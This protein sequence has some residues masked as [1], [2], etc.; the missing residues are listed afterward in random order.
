[1]PRPQQR[2]LHAARARF[3]VLVA[4]R[5]FG[6]TVFCINELISRA[7]RCRKRDPRFAYVAPFQ[8]QAK[9]VA[10]SYLKQYT[11]AIPGIAVSETELSVDLPPR[12]GGAGR[13]R[14]RLYGAD[15][16]DR[17]RGLYFDG[18]I[19]DEYA[20]MDPRVWSE[21]IRP[22]LADRAGWAIFI[23]TPLGRNAFC[24]LYEAATQGFARE[25]GTRALDPDWTGYL[26]K[27]TETGIIPAA[28]LEAARRIM[29]P[30]QYA[31]EFECSFDA[32][33]PGAYYATLIDQ[34][35][36]A[37]RLKPVPH[38]PALPVHTAWDLGIG[39]PTAIWFAQVVHGEPR[40]IDYYESSGVGLEH[41]VAQLHAGHRAEWVYG[42]HFFPPDL[43][44]REIGTG[45]TRSGTLKGFGVAP[46][47][48]APTAVDDGISQAR[49]MLRKS[50][51][52][53][54][55]CGDGLKALRQ[56]RS[57]WD[58]R[59]QVLKPVPLHDWTSHASDALRY[60]A[61][62]LGRHLIDRRP[63][64]DPALS[65]L[66]RAIAGRPRYADRDSRAARSGDR[67]YGW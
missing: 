67:P 10:W 12:E 20:Q 35:E 26:F 49:F 15:N 2:D 29:T 3:K 25:D 38:E 28:E 40:L 32:A 51:F 6:K 50:W 42:L 62:G 19:L 17:L 46:T 14:I 31:Q 48:L 56:Y 8:V 30:D 52:N 61:I 34:A 58:D 33:V 7:R 21:V 5:R 47:I 55:R 41:Y 54:T 53:T 39:D 1:V 24:D 16:A 60:L 43:Q 22:A 63:L 64:V 57:D 9:D 65:S 44:S 13:A 45:L 59:R 23:G 18:V 36:R 4:H 11:A 27:A 37:G 66:M